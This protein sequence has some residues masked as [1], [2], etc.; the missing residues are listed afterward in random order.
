[1]T[2]RILWWPKCGGGL[3]FRI[4]SGVKSRTTY[5][6]VAWYNPGKMDLFSSEVAPGKLSMVRNPKFMDVNHAV[7]VMSMYSSWS[8]VA[9]MKVITTR[10]LL[11]L[12]TKKICDTSWMIVWRSSVY[13]QWKRTAW[14][15]AREST[16]TWTKSEEIFRSKGM[17]HFEFW[18]WVVLKVVLQLAVRQK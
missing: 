4:M 1:M 12:Y 18:D 10:N 8:Q 3:H 11:K 14:L 17:Q 5:C 15:K 6:Y 2:Y 9:V 13:H 16:P 7:N